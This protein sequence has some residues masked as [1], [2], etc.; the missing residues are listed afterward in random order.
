[1][2]IEQHHKMQLETKHP[3]GAEE[4]YCPTCGRRFLMH[5]PPEYKRVILEAGD[6]MAI[7]SGGKDGLVM[8]PP[9]LGEAEAPDLSEEMRAALEEALKDVDFDGP[10]SA[11][12]L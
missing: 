12:D 4:W 7:H 1:M 6:E 5:W 3:S 2:I 8:S 10:P 11:D 9:R